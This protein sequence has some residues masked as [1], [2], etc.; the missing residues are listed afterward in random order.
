MQ[1]LGRDLA[2]DH[3][4][5]RTQ[6]V[7]QQ[8]FQ[9]QSELTSIAKCCWLLK[10]KRRKG[11]DAALLLATTWVVI[12]ICGR[13]TCADSEIKGGGGIARGKGWRSSS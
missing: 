10:V 8:G 13:A 4:T 7:L 11:D 2:I 6:S 5:G 3:Q 9:D 1:R 12:A